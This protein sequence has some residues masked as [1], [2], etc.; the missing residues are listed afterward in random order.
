VPLAERT[1]LIG[2]LTT[3][4]LST[5]LRQ[6]RDWLDRGLRIAVAVN[7]S[8]RNLLDP[9]FADKAVELLR[10]IDV[11]AELLTFEITETS[12]MADPERSI[13]VLHRLHALGLG[14]A[15]DDFGTGYSSLAYL[16]RLPVDEVKIDKAF[17]LGMGTDLGD[18]AIVRA[19]VELGHSLGLRVVAEGVEDELSRDLLEGMDCDVIQGYLLSRALAPDR[20]DAWLA[21]RS[22]PRPEQAGLPGRRLQ[23]PN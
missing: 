23:I 4:V 13:P 8:A 10:E 11:P 19:I 17:V 5:A 1:G 18:L 9:D 6:C 15:V 12:V 3:H 22:V 21:A 16:R 14:L 20:F 2:P 7:L